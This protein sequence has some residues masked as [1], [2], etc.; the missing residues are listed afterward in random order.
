MKWIKK[1]LPSKMKMMVFGGVM[2]VAVVIDRYFDLGLTKLILKV[3]W[4][5][6]KGMLPF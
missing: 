6:V 4:A 1:F 2:G 5:W 3:G